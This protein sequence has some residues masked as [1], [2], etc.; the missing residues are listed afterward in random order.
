MEEKWTTVSGFPDYKVSDI[1]RIKKGAYEMSFP[2]DKDGYLKTALRDIEGK[3]KYLRVHRIVAINFI[4]NPENK[5]VVNHKNGDKR[6]NRVVN[7]EWNTIS[8]NTKHGFDALGREGNHTTSIPIKLINIESKEETFFKDL[9]S[10]SEYLGI[11]DVAV[12][13][14]LKRKE[15]L[16]DKATMLKKYHAERV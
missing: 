5:P 12:G 14:Y 2:Q 16:G 15:R 9:K 1:G 10:L 3:R 8:E 7:L 4:D 11:S 13:N 6:D